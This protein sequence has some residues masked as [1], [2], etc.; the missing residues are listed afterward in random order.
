M[1]T[2]EYFGTSRVENYWTKDIEDA[3]KF[4]QQNNFILDDY[5]E[6]FLKEANTYFQVV[7]VLKF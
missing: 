7:E 2:K 5:T 4:D 3:Y 6:D 1:D